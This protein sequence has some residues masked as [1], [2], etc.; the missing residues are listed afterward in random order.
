[1]KM[2]ASNN[3]VKEIYKFCNKFTFTRS[4]FIIL[5]YVCK[6]VGIEEDF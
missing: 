2:K 6:N 4:I 1:M 5:N 3:E